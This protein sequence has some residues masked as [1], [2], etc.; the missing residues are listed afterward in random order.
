[1]LEV[2]FSKLLQ[3]QVGYFKKPGFEFL[4]SL[5]NEVQER[6][7][8]SV[9][10][11]TF[12][13]SGMWQSTGNVININGPFLKYFKAGIC[14]S[15]QGTQCMHIP[16]RSKSISMNQQFQTEKHQP[17]VLL[18]CIFKATHNHCKKTEI[19]LSECSFRR[20]TENYILG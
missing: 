18:L 10:V 3:S 17:A 9:D 19:L 11:L 2:I 16:Y 5:Q 8:V 12:P 1:M 14:H 13:L 6:N 20:A 4:I 15:S 7:S